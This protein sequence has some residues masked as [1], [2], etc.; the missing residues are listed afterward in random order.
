MNAHTLL[1]HIMHV[2]VAKAIASAYEARVIAA[3]IEGKPEPEIPGQQLLPMFCVYLKFITA[4]VVVFI[5]KYCRCGSFIIGLTSNIP[6][7]LRVKLVL[8][9][10]IL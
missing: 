3:R 4:L 1:I 6:E 7:S 2:A 10:I 9:P 5:D 8:P